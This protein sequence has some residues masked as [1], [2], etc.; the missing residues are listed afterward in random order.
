MVK[1][2]LTLLLI[3]S[4]L[5]LTFTS[6]TFAAETTV[7]DREMAIASALAYVPLQK[8]KTMAQNFDIGR[9][10]GISRIV[11]FVNSKFN[12]HDYAT[13]DELN[14]WL[15]ADFHNKEFSEKSMAAFVLEKDNNVIIVF[16]GT[17]TEVL[18]DIKYGLKN[19]HDQE[20]YAKK[21]VSDILN[22]YSSKDGNY[23]IYVTGHSL[24]GYLAQI[25]GSHVYSELK[26]NNE[27]YN[28]LSL[29]RIVYF[30]GIGINFLTYF[31]DK[32]N[33]GNQAETIANLKDLG[34]QGKL[35]SYYTYGD[36]VSALGVHYGEMRALLPSIDSIAYHRDNYKIISSITANAKLYNKL[37]S[38]IE[39]DR[40]NAFKTDIK[41][42]K[43]F[44]KLGNSLISYINLTHEADAFAC[45]GLADSKNTPTL[46]VINKTTALSAH[47]N[48]DTDFVESTK[49]IKLEALTSYASTKK[50][51]WYV[52]D[53]KKDWTL[54]KT[55]DL[56]NLNGQAPE[57]TLKI[58]IN[59]IQKG[60]S[61][62]Y[63]VV[64]HYD[65]NYISSKY[66]YNTTKK[67]YEYVKTDM[68]KKI[69]YKPISKIVEVKRKETTKTK[70]KKI[71]SIFRRFL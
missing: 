69:E 14:D 38:I 44:Y 55:V 45:I 53:N 28:T 29:E 61:K 30:N 37:H 18:G 13:I 4:A 20:K 8:N 62:Y 23:N 46:K 60:N 52:S 17:D 19:Y 32:Y 15:V 16:R 41:D 57:N 47:L 25:A 65:D 12:L 2:C 42:A 3:L 22:E 67:Q 34:N 24:G 50:Y 9:F 33:Y 68:S 39:R 43:N 59:S 64:A 63:K 36:L 11:N 31:G 21:Y 35:I 7:S 49:S 5:L 51:E 56:Y 27:K 58:D 48:K 26:N 6:S 40:F 71:F 1:K 66:T 54:L 10:S 70:I